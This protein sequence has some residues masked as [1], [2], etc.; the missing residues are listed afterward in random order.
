MKLVMVQSL[1][2]RIAAENHFGAIFPFT[3]EMQPHFTMR[4][5]LGALRGFR[6]VLGVASD[7]EQLRDLILDKMV[8]SMIPHTIFMPKDH[9]AAIVFAMVMG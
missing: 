9:F 8:T 4:A 2:W 5:S 1:E 3:M 6:L 7:K